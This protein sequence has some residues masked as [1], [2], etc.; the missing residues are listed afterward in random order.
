MNKNEEGKKKIFKNIIKKIR[1]EETFLRDSSLS[2]NL[3][4]ELT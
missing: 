1:E 4:H 3:Q 2:T